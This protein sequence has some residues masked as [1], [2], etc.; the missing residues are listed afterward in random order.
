M[1]ETFK[2]SVNNQL[3]KSDETL[4]QVMELINN[5]HLR[6]GLKKLENALENGNE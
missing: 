1:G 4:K 3:S 6:K 2:M 5:G